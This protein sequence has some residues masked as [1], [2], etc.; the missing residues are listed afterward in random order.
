[1][2]TWKLNYNPVRA[3]IF[4]CRTFMGLVYQKIPSPTCSYVPDV[5]KKYDIVTTAQEVAQNLTGNIISLTSL[6][7]QEIRT[8]QNKGVFIGWL[9]ESVHLGTVNP[10]TVGCCTLVK[11][12]TI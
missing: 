3:S 6:I 4:T 12:I 11:S 5:P 1:M 10:G 2:T 9:L 8:I 7:L